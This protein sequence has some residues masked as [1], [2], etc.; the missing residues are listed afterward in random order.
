M[1]QGD[2]AMRKTSSIWWAAM[3]V[4]VATLL[5][6]ASACGETK[7]I[8]V[9]GE[10]VIVEEIVTEVKEVPVEVIVEKVVTE[11]KEVEVPGET[12]VVEKEIVKTVEIPGA[13]REVIKTEIKEVEVP[14]ETIVVEKEVVRNVE[15]EVVKEVIVEAERP[16]IRPV[17]GSTLT[18][19]AK[20]VGPANW[21]RPIANYPYNTMSTK[22]GVSEHLLDVAPDAS[23]FP[24][25]ASSWEVTDEGILWTIRKGVP[26][27][28]PAYGTVNVE[29]VHWSFENGAR[30][31]SVSHYTKWY[32]DDFQ[33]PTIVGDDQLMWEWGENGG[34]LRYVL[35]T[36]GLGSGTG[37]ENKD[38]YDTVGEET[39]S[40]VFMGT[41]PYRVVS[42]V[43]DD[44][45]T[46]AGVPNHWRD[47]PDWETVRVIEV[48]EQATRIAMMK[49][50]QG[51]VTDVAISLLDQVTD[52]PNLRLVKGAVNP[53]KIGAVFFMGGNYQIETF[54][55]GTPNPA[56]NRPDL[57]WVGARGDAESKLAAK[58]IRLAM[59][60][61]IDRDGLNEYILYGEGCPQYIYVMDSCH[62]RYDEKWSHE[63]D[64]EK[65]KQLMAD[66][67]YPDGFD[68]PIWIPTGTT[69]DT[70]IEVVEAVIPMWEENLGIKTEIDRS[71]YSA[72]R[73]D[74]FERG[75]INGVQ[76]FPWG[77]TIGLLNYTD[78]LCDLISGCTSWNSGY[79]D[80]MGYDVHTKFS[81]SYKSLDDAW[82]ALIPYNE[83]HSHLG[84]LPVITSLDWEDVL[85]V[86]PRV[87]A[88]DIVEHSLD[89]AELE[90]IKIN[91]E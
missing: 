24:M 87:G 54:P 16:K 77:G 52:D 2:K 81:A 62:P 70:F 53:S 48:P 11:V 78:Y 4:G 1:E 17:P 71:V 23:V 80:P 79:D 45:I 34:T 51:D 63:Y 40:S 5:V 66:G 30:E 61:A 49:S 6:F 68:M 32:K 58:N 88:V 43:N 36:Q 25:I 46:L 9:P 65:A 57:P 91:W 10:T 37:I 12:I 7:I 73:P 18:V 35:T 21:H 39:H 75:A 90:G 82:E 56:E 44:M 22:L 64:L 42:H 55:D 76:A 50:G 83:Y 31:G 3:M 13:V 47:T 8:E 28:D 72:R 89:P 67:G 84:E 14:G 69:P 38:Y 26:W 27:H 86:G 15:V 41:G 60:Y 20:D 29:D 74:F 85:V 33:N 59:S 19:V